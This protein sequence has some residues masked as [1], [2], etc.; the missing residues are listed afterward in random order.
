MSFFQTVMSENVTFHINDE[1]LGQSYTFSEK[2]GLFGTHICT[3]SY[4]GSYTPPRAYKQSIALL[5]SKLL[6]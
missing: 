5:S 4:I 3:M 1:K 2:R 6:S